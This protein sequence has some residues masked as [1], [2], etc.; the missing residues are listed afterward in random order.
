MITGHDVAGQ[1][2]SVTVDLKQWGQQV[3]PSNAEGNVAAWVA[4]RVRDVLQP[5]QLSVPPILGV[6]F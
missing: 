2:Q 1:A 6:F 4:G 5:S 3:E